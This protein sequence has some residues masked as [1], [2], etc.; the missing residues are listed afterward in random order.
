MEPNIRLEL[1]TQTSGPVLRAQAEIK[2][3]VFKRMTHSG[4]P[5]K[6]HKS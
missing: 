4:T 6:V 5:W 2:S 1:T 3:W